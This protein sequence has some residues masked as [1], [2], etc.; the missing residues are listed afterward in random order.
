MCPNVPNV[1][2]KIAG[3]SKITTIITIDHNRN[4]VY[5]ITLILSYLLIVIAFLK[6]MC[7]NVPN[8]VQKNSQMKTTIIMFLDLSF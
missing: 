6:T 5:N 4:R 7:P 3:F 2:K 8:V 1:V